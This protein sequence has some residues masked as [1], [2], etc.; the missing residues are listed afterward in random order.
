MHRA[1]KGGACIEPW[2]HCPRCVHAEFFKCHTGFPKH[3][4]MRLDPPCIL[5]IT[6]QH[7]IALAFVIFQSQLRTEFVQSLFAVESKAMHA[8]PIRLKN[9]QTSRA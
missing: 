6:Q 5:D 8:G 9:L 4:Q 7:Q 1:E 2:L 3:R